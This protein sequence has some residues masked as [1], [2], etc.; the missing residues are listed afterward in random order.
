[1]PVPGDQ[2]A[3]GGSGVQERPDQP[4]GFGEV[5]RGGDGFQCG[6]VPA[7]P[8]GGQ[9]QQDPGL[10]RRT[11]DIGGPGRSADPAARATGRAV[12]ARGAPCASVTRSTAAAN[13]S[14]PRRGCVEVLIGSSGSP[15]SSAPGPARPRTSGPTD[16]AGRPPRPARS[17][18]RSAADRAAAA[19]PRAT[20]TPTAAMPSANRQPVSEPRLLA[21]RPAVD[22]CRRPRPAGSR[23][24]GSYPTRHT[25]PV[26]AV[27]PPSRGG[28]PAAADGAGPPVRLPQPAVDHV[29]HRQ[30]GA[31]RS[32]G[33]GPS[34]V[35]GPAPRAGGQVG[36]RG[37][38]VPGPEVTHTEVVQADDP[39]MRGGRARAAAAPRP[40]GTAAGSTTRPRRRGRGDRSCATVVAASS[41]SAGIADVVRRLRQEL[42]RVGGVP[43]HAPGSRG[44]ENA[45]SPR[46]AACSTWA[47][48]AARRAAGSSA[49]ANAGASGVRISGDAEVASNR[50]TSSQS[51]AAVA[52]RIAGIGRPWR[53]TT[54]PPGV[55]FLGGARLFQ[56]QPVLH[57][58]PQQ[59]VVPEPAAVIA[60]A[61]DEGVSGDQAFQQSLA[62][63]RG[64]STRWPA[65][66]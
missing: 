1:M 52:C 6:G 23:P 13:P 46:R 27:R 17:A 22:R 24:A 2:P 40:A 20:A 48:R 36:L 19:W 50:P 57:Q 54:G 35:P 58:L 51:P 64:R 3:G 47:D 14:I 25:G 29:Q 8:I 39:V 33:T 65:A 60:Q 31:R 43:V 62:V 44:A 10:D 63:A 45:R 34:R 41:S 49:A 15:A 61:D 7:L 32:P 12:P 9:R 37:G 42:G 16:P 30:V 55:Q 38:Q 59:R 11:Q 28:P 21:A 4:L 56:G 26:P 18:S 66:G 53:R 5:D